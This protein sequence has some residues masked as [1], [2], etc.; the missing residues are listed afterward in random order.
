MESLIQLDKSL[1]L[2]LN[3]LNSSFGDSLM[4]IISS[5]YTWIPLYVAILL[6]VILKY[7]MKSVWVVIFAVAAVAL[8]DLVSVHLFKD[9]F[10]RLR[11]SQNPEF[12]DQ[13]HIVNN[14]KGG[15]YGFVSSHAANSFAIA[16]FTLLVIRKKWY[17][18]SIILWAIIVS[19]SR[20]YLGVHYP[21]DILGGAIV[22]ILFGY[23]LF[24]I[25]KRYVLRKTDFSARSF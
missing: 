19:Y 11:P 6:W 25:M 8:S 14:Y 21:G 23:V 9:V 16:V 17:T 1:F 12:V 2:F 5:K 20:I 3:S 18:Y 13:I 7:R 15:L 24:Q 4:W 10:C 22:G